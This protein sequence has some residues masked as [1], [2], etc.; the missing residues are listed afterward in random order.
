[1]QPGNPLRRALSPALAAAALACVAACV[2]VPA[3]AGAAA[4]PPGAGDLSARLAELAKPSLRSAPPAKQ[5]RELGL[6]AEGPGSLLRDGNRVLVEVRFDH[7]AAAGVEDLRQDGAKV[8]D[9]S[10]RYQTVTVAAK[11]AQLPNLSGVPRVAEANEVLTPITAAVPVCPSGPVVSE[12][13][14][15][16]RAAEARE[17]FGVDGR[18]VEVGILSDS[19]DMATGVATNATQDAADGDLPGNSCGPTPA[20]DVLQDY[21]SSK[22][23][24]SDEGRAMAQIVHD[25]APR[26]NLDFATGFTGMTGFASNVEALA[27]NGASVIVDDVSYFEE[28][29]F[30]EGPIG[31]A[32]SRVTA[33]GVTY[34]SS[35]GNNNLR[36]E[37]KDVASW[38]TPHYRDAGECPPG[39]VSLSEAYEEFEEE[40]KAEHPELELPLTGLNASHCL[41]FDPDESQKDTTYGISVEDGAELVVDLQWAEPWFDVETDLDAFLLDSGGEVI[42]EE[43]KDN[44]NG[45]ERPYEVLGWE[46]ATGEDQEVQLVIN[47]YSGEDPR[48][49]FALLQNGGG[50][51]PT[52]YRESA[53]E[54]V[55]G[56]TIFGHNGAQ[57]AITAAAIS[58][59]TVAAP[60]PYSSR[61]PV[62]HYFGPVD[63]VAPAEPLATPSVLSKPDVTATDCGRTSFFVPSGSVYR[64]CGTSA[65]A[66]HAAAVAALMRQRN[67][68]F[69]PTQIRAALTGSA[70]PIDALGSSAVGAG[71]VDAVGAL[72]LEPAPEAGGS[73]TVIVF[74]PPETS[75]QTEQP[76]PRPAPNTFFRHH[77]ARIVRTRARTARAVFRF[78]SDQSGVTFLCKVDRGRFHRCGRRFVRRY[79]L[80]RH[81]LRVKARNSDGGVDPTPA[82]FR[83][84]VKRVRHGV[85]KRRH[86][87]HHH[88]R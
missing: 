9:V 21:S 63:S 20:V 49:K 86:T 22:E 11:P 15:Q 17:A 16:L 29:F 73:G 41:D 78:G 39:L 37:G 85:L 60:E 26:A 74:P 68:A 35:A 38:E 75:T 87:R 88:R 2:A 58:H 57:D 14:I 53:G 25:L 30:Q 32:V 61:G 44:V 3:S 82:A 84:R 7:G 65:A 69:T 50:A 6:A 64:F 66:P 40:L 27:A 76:A 54:D 18:G 23:P 31:A 42:A 47:R 71:L 8:V 77:P 56:P 72:N 83:F 59:N 33:G 62:T 19:F 67:P 55:V 70:R 28:P 36:S 48:L 43:T 12:G 79:R 52:E 10:P 34:V 5:A 80:G 51:E 81:V 45:T 24:P 46:N 13:D 4:A 1:M